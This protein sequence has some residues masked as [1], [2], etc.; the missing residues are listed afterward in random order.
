MKIKMYF[1]IIVISFCFCSCEKFVEIDAPDHKITSEEVFSSDETAISAMKGI[2]NQ[3]SVS[4]FSNG[5]TSS[6]TLLAA[7]SADNLRN[8]RSTNFSRMEF[9][10]NEILPTNPNNQNLWASAYNIIFLSNSLLE[11]I[12]NSD[13]VS[14]NVK[15][16]L[17]GEAKFIRAFTYFHLVNL[18]GEV[19]LILVTDFQQNELATRDPEE[20]IYQQIIKDLQASITHLGEEY[21]GGD[22]TQ[23]NRFAAMAFLSRV[24][25]YLEDWQLAVDMSSQII[26]ASST[27]EVLEDP[28]QVFL[29]NSREAI[30]QISP[31]GRGD[32]ATHTEEGN[33]FII[34]PVFSFF[35]SV[36]LE[37]D[38]VATFTVQDKRLLN[39]I[40]YNEALEAYYSYKYKIWNSNE[41][42]IEEFSMVLRLA[43]QYLI[44]AEARAEQDKLKEA[45]EDIDVIRGRAGI[46]LVSQSYPGIGK[47]ALLDI[48]L[49]ERRKELFTEWGHRWLDLKRTGRAG[50]VLGQDNPLWES[51]DVLYPIPGE[52]RMRNPQL[53]QNPGY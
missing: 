11:G 48:I 6:I 30:W 3:L 23:V 5:S 10:E 39:W 9:E 49:E 40:S 51:T 31:V 42:P 22:R 34:H 20:K 4:S 52:E 37:N 44:R 16:R 21:P 28:N 7:L 13:N 1:K 35:A 18:Y 45:I 17:E 12:E 50:E 53:T 8:I 36:Q 26:A 43:E 46:D 15:N 29:A 14:I 47:E 41:Q 24:A 32:A 19:P 25:L 33:L 38:F 27:Y 2:Y